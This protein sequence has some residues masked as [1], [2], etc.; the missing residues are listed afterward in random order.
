MQDLDYFDSS[1]YSR[2]H[3]LY[4]ARN[5]KVLEKMK[6]ETHGVPTEEFVGLRTKMYPILFTEDNKPVEKKTAKGISKNLTKRKIRLQD[7]KTCLFEKKVQMAR[8]NQIRSDN[9]QLYSLTLNKK[10]LS[11]QDDKRYMS[12]DGRHTLAC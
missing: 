4:S 9:H 10:S 12:E 6:D 3:F 11:T 8:M 2:D 5:K 7:Y 1:E